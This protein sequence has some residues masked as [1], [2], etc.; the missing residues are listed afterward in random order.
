MRKGDCLTVE[1]QSLMA[2][3]DNPFN[4]IEHRHGVDFTLNKNNQ[5]QRRIRFEVRQSSANGDTESPARIFRTT[6]RDM[7]EI[8]RI[9]AAIPRGFMPHKFRRKP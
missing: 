7:T 4:P 5:V 1:F 3:Q 9:V 8:P 6:E 2:Q